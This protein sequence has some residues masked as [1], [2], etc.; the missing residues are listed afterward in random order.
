MAWTSPSDKTTGD[1]VTAAIWNAQLGTTGNMAQTAP[2]KVT[3]AGDMVYATGANAIARL[4][5]GSTGD[6]LTVSGGVPAW[7]AASAFDGIRAQFR[8]ARRV[9]A[10]AFPYGL[11]TSVTDSVYTIS[12]YGGMLA[13][14]G[15][16][17]PTV[18]IFP[19][20]GTVDA[21]IQITGS[22]NRLNSWWGT[23]STFYNSSASLA[24]AIRPDKNPR[25]LV[26]WFPGTSNAN[27]TTTWCGFMAGGAAPSATAD[28][29][30]LR[31]NT[32]GNLYFVTRQSASETTTD[33]GARPTT[34]TSYEIYTEDAGVTWKCRNDTTGAEVASHTT[35]VPTATTAI[36]YGL[37][38][39]SATGTLPAA[40][41]VYMRVEA[42]MGN[43]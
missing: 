31:A 25:M 14:S 13:T 10:E 38:G 11:I 19:A 42:G 16:S 15:G 32:T 4:G 17:S 1:V 39:I 41:L 23:N 36:A 21:Y 37:G 30:Y 27:L 5:I 28:G 22:T 20:S 3:T 24:A 8:A 9:Y 40:F 35:D 7:G 26:R 34:P 18:S 6:V 2:A 33:L 12:G 29:A 43:A